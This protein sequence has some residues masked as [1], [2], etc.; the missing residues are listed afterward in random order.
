V[1]RDDGAGRDGTWAARFVRP[2]DGELDPITA[3]LGNK[4]M[5]SFRTTD[6]RAMLAPVVE[7]AADLKT[8]LVGIM[9]LNKKVDVNNALL[10]ISDSLAFGATARHVYAVVDDAEHERKLLVKGK[11]NLATNAN[12][13]LA[14]R[15]GGR[16]VGVDP[17]T[18]KSIFAPYILWKKTLL[19]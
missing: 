17:E 10:R 9:H 2:S 3:Y 19:T 11:N 6:V 18:G 14:F 13:A 16:E 4:K 8:A 5:D 1:L 7:F 15:F 12:K